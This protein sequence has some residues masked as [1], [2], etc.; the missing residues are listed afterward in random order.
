MD[1]VIRLSTFKTNRM[2]ESGKCALWNFFF[3]VGIKMESSL[4]TPI[5]LLFFGINNII[6]IYS[7][8]FVFGMGRSTLYHGSQSSVRIQRKPIY[9]YGNIQW[10]ST[11]LL[12]ER[13]NVSTDFKI[14]F[15]H[16]IRV[17]VYTIYSAKA[18][19]LRQ[20]PTTKSN[21]WLV[22]VC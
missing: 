12:P 17:S 22:R 3:F 8:S 20:I 4:Q 11:Y 16:F 13:L 2:V 9:I 18:Y 7:G 10:I 15:Q 19:T 14:I 1:K 21:Y 5:Q 6:L